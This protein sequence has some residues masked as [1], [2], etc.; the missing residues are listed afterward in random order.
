[1]KCRLKILITLILL[2]SLTYAQSNISGYWD[3]K[4]KMLTMNLDFQLKIE[5]TKNSLTALMSIPSQALKDY[6]LQVFTINKNK[7]HFELPSQAGIANFDGELKA[8]SITGKILQAGIQGSFHLVRGVEP[9][10]SPVTE[11][12]KAEPLPYSE[13]EVAFKSGRILLAG[14]LTR[15]KENFKYPAVIL[16]TGNGPQNRDE[17]IFGFKIF[18]RIADFLTRRG[19][20]VLRYDDRGVGGSTGNTM[21]ST[22]AEFADDAKAAIDF[23]KK[24]P[25]I[26][27]KKIGF[28]G[29]SEGA[30]IASLVASYSSDV[31]FVVLISGS[32]VPGGDLLLEQ[33]RLILNASGVENNLIEKNR[34][35][36]VKINNVLSG[37]EDFSS[38][39]NDI[40]IFA[41]KDF[42]SLSPEIKNSILDKKS[43]L[44]SIVE[45]QI[46]M[47]DNPWFRFFVKYDPAPS[48][49][50]VKVPVLMIFGGL[51][52][53]VSVHQN[54]N[55]MEEALEKGGNKN[56]KTVIFP[57][58]NHLYQAAKSGIPAEYE[59]LK[60]EFVPGFLDTIGNWIIPIIK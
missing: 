31:A 46:V 4:I 51:D 58:A 1:M 20:A 2:A 14:T 19:I 22:T 30:I 7:V 23:L 27:S 10:Q 39:R 16:L 37:G 43:Y 33:Q 26:D 40:E 35:L 59:S 3:G 53:Q 44:N 38:I 24:L 32:G 54:K 13:E 17:D 42:E 41:E 12:K 34:E 28:I 15:P 52:L 50:K 45:S 11:V 60:K 6:Q 48:L 21:Q 18:E 8:D 55:K 56:Y 25:N 57:E 9:K 49:K 47:F 29:H 36:Q 5:Q